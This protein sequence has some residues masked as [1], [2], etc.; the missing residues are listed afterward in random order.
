MALKKKAAA[1]FIQAAVPEKNKGLLRKK[2]GTKEGENIPKGE[3]AKKIGILRKEGAG[4]KKLPAGKLK[5]LRELLF[6]KTVSKLRPGKK[7]S[8]MK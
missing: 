1:D 8:L 4:D 5:L 6:A 7:R 3:I 2:L